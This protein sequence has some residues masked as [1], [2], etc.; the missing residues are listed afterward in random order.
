MDARESDSA[1]VHFRPR[2]AGGDSG[3][4]GPQPG[5][6]ARVGRPAS[7][8]MFFSNFDSERILF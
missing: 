2:R 3:S 7:E 1:V 4:F 8:T 6:P 5:S